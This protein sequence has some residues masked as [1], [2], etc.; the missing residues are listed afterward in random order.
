MGCGGSTSR[1]NTTGKMCVMCSNTRG[2]P[3]LGKG[4]AMHQPRGLQALRTIAVT[5]VLCHLQTPHSTANMGILYGWLCAL[6]Q[7]ALQ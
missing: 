3:H 1:I 7:H 4:P 2:L 5:H 6:L